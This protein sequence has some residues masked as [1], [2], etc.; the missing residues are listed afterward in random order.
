M[1]VATDHMGDA[2]VEIIDHHGQHIGGRAIR[3]EHD[4]IVELVITEGH[5]ALH[6]VIDHRLAVAR[7]L[8]ADRIRRAVGVRIVR[9]VAPRAM[10]EGRAPRGT[11][12]LAK[13]FDLVLGGEA[14]IGMSTGQ[15]LMGDLGMA[16]DAGE[17]ADGLTIPIEPKPAHAVENGLRRLRGR[18]GAVGIFDPQQELAT[19][20][21]GIKPVEQRRARGADMH[22]ARG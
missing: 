16:G 1:V 3:A 18:A 5:I 2:H 14:F 13:G 11:G 7:R 6:R 19:T 21:A 22:D 12:C 9:G 4:H 20:R 8:E 15:H 10:I 17:L